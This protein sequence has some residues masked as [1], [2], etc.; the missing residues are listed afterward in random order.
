MVHQNSAPLAQMLQLLLLP[1]STGV[2][3]ALARFGL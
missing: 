3:R 1:Q 2:G